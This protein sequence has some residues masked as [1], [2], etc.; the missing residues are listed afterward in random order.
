M[1]GTIRDTDSVFVDLDQD[2]KIGAGEGLDIAN[3][4]ASKRFGPGQFTTGGSRPVYYTPGGETDVKPGIFNT[5]ISIEYDDASLVD[6][7]AVSF[8]SQLAYFQVL[9]DYIPIPIPN[10]ASND[11][12]EVRI[13]CEAA[14]GG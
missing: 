2:G 6:P 9:A 14:G 5:E 8:V 7:E 4:V 11:I 12:T 10:A 1:S 3:G 13:T